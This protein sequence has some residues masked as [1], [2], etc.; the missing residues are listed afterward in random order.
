MDS[1]HAV[2]DIEIRNFGRI[3]RAL[4]IN[5]SLVTF[6]KLLNKSEVKL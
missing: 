1:I 2:N 4:P 3:P 5:Y 6:V